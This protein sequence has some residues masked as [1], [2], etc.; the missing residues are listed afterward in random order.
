[1]VLRVWIFQALIYQIVTE[2]YNNINQGHKNP[3]MYNCVKCCT[4]IYVYT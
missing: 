4:C 2:Y 1:M 3:E